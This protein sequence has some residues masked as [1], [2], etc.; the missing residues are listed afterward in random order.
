MF[1]WLSRYI[2]KVEVLGVGVELREVAP[3]PS[4]AAPEIP[5]ERPIL[6][7]T[8][9]AAQFVHWHCGQNNVSGDWYLRVGVEE[10][11]GGVGRYSVELESQV[12]EADEVFV[13]QGVRVVVAR[14]QVEKLRGAVVGHHSGAGGVGFFVDNPRLPQAN[15]PPR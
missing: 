9:A 11:P 2:R 4:A 12:G 5:S 13:S 8:P 15:E 10:L 3:T 1:S 6:T 7:L 14:D